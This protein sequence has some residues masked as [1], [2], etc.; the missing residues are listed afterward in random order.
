MFNI[1]RT[2][3]M[4][5]TGHTG[6]LAAALADGDVGTAGM[7]SLLLVLATVTCAALLSSAAR[8]LGQLM[9]LLKDLLRMLALA[10]VAA[11]VVLGALAMVI[12]DLLTTR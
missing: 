10:L 5:H 7:T 4:H 1:I 8:L 3:P 12:N 9:A 6:I 2:V 11:L